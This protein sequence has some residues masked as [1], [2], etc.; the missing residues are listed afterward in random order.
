MVFS[1]ITLIFREESSAL[2]YMSENHNSMSLAKK[3]S[4]RQREE[5]RIEEGE[6]RRREKNE[7][8]RREEN[9]RQSSI[10]VLYH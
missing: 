8:E 5:R 2:I 4:K 9:E 10:Y 1:I 3:L 7:R 6:Q